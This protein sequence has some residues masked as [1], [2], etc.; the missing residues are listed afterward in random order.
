MWVAQLSIQFLVK[1]LT[2]HLGSS[3][4]LEGH[5]I[6]PHIHSMLT[7]DSAVLLLPPLLIPLLSLSQINKY[8]KK[9][10]KPQA[11]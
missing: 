11:V 10:Q 7:K 5:E 4:D 6:K 8:L 1:H 9:K 3:H 2:P